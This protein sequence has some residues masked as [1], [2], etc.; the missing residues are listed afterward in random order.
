MAKNK[1]GE[2]VLAT[3]NPVGTIMSK[4]LNRV[5]ERT[6]KLTPQQKEWIQDT[7]DVAHNPFGFAAKKIR[8]LF[9]GEEGYEDFL[10]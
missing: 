7:S 8:R 6:E 5:A 2:V 1:A 3:V 4:A 9:K 10:E